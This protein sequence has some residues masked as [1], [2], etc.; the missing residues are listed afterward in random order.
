MADG[1]TKLI[2]NTNQVL[3]HFPYCTGAKTGYTNAAGC[4]LVSSASYNG[5]NVIAVILGSTS[6]KVWEEPEALLK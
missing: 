5:K 3:K 2:S 4:G 1:K 6:P